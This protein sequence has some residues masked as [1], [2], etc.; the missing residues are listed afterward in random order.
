MLETSSNISI[1]NSPPSLEWDEVSGKI[2][3]VYPVGNLGGQAYENDTLGVF[4]YNW[5][6]ADGDPPGYLYQ[7][8]RYDDGQWID[9]ED[10]NSAT[11]GP[12]HFV[13]GD[14]IRVWV[15]PYDGEDT[16]VPRNDPIIIS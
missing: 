12:E 11:L 16:G 4:I 8:Q 6:D 15:T 1:Q 10:A 5:T 14:S 13:S 3:E 7:W 2:I 9:I